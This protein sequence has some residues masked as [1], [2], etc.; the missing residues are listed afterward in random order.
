MESPKTNSVPLKR[1]P[2]ELEVILESV[3]DIAH[4]IVAPN[5]EEIDREG[6][7]PEES[8]RALQ[9][10]SLGGLTIPEEFGGLGQGSFGILRVSEILGQECAST[11][12]CFGMH[13]VGSAVLSAKATPDQID[14]YLTPIVQGKH[15][16]TLSLSESGSGSH[17]YIPDTKLEAT[18]NDQYKINGNKTFVTNGSHADSYVISTVAAEPDAPIGQFSCIVV[19]DDAKGLKWGEAWDGLGMRGN[20]SRSLDLNDVLVPKSDLLGEEGDQIWYVF[21][22]V[23]PYFLMAMSGA[24]LGIASSAIEIAREH[25]IKRNY[26]A[27]GSNLSQFT[28]LQH[29]LGTLWGNL[30]RTR[31]LAYH[32][33]A[34][35]DSGDPDSLPA[36]F[37][38]KA[39]VAECAVTI[40]NEVMTLT[41]GMAYRNGSKLHQLLRD[42]RASHVMAP[43]TDMLRIWTGRTLLGQPIL[44]A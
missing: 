41:G 13:C 38:T 40:V 5:A 6:F 22:V 37:T 12:M 2:L 30:E 23:A 19:S 8:I 43:T 44:G 24:Y 4:S 14:R 31:R 25:L 29:R 20:S 7:W 33:A 11:A 9:S 10:A 42:A 3:Q 32:A 17:F 34:S 16:T 36:V 27:T 15:L 39:E 21:Q 1:Y 35:F 18:S 26:S 28:V